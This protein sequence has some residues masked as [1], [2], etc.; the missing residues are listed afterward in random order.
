MQKI[1]KLKKLIHMVSLTPLFDYVK[2]G[3]ERIPEADCP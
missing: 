1:N 2:M 3:K